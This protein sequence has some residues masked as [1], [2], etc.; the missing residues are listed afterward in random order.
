MGA[1]V[2]RTHEGDILRVR[3]DANALI[4]SVKHGR[5]FAAQSDRIET[6]DLRAEAWSP[7]LDGFK[8]LRVRAG[9]KETGGHEGLR[10]ELAYRCA[11]GPEGRVVGLGD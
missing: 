7:T 6:V 8:V 1:H 10:K 11:D 3:L 4:I 2:Q 5:L 9:N